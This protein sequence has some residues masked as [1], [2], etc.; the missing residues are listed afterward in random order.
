MTLSHSAIGREYALL[1]GFLLAMTAQDILTELESPGSENTR[2]TLTR[3]GAKDPC[4]G[5]K[6]ADLQKIRKRI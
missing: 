1:I 4:F 2:K 5:V 3:H 6:I